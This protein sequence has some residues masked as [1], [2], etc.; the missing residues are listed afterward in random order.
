[1]S[2]DYIQ[3]RLFCKPIKRIAEI[4]AGKRLDSGDNFDFLQKLQEKKTV[5]KV[6]AGAVLLSKSGE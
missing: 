3:K 1:M 5:L 6:F 4:T 2:A